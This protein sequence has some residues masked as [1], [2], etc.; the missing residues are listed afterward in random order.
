M[1]VL[2]YAKMVCLIDTFCDFCLCFVLFYLFSLLIISGN[3]VSGVMVNS[4]FE[5]IKQLLGYFFVYIN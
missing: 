4:E 2:V 5:T 3:Y 1:P